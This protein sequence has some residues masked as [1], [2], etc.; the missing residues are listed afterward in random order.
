MPKFGKPSLKNLSECH[1]DLQLIFNRVI[2]N[3]D[4]SVIEGNRPKEEQE[5]AFHSGKSKVKWPD[6]K[7]NSMPSM[8]T[9]VCPYPIDWNDTKRFYHFAGYVLGVANILLE[10]GEITHRLRWGGDWDSD[11]VLG[12]QNFN[13]LPHFELVG[14]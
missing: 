6:S 3:Y 13:D 7:H 10:E 14:V 11:N 2:E 12:D 4:C 5:K 8:A 9:D 1:K